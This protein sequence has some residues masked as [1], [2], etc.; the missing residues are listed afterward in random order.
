MGGAH[1]ESAQE[2]RAIRFRAVNR[3]GL[4]GHDPGLQRHHLLPLQ[5]RGARCLGRFIDG[6]GSHRIGFDDFRRNGMLLPT[7]ESTAIRTALPLHRGPHRLYSDLV[8]DRAG[9]IER[10]WSVTRL[11]NSEE[12]A[13]TAMM[14]L[15][16]L[17]RALRRRLLD[18]ARPLRLNWRTPLGSE[19]DFT[20]LDRMIDQLWEA[21]Q[22]SVTA[23]SAA[24]AA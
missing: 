6:I 20:E 4:P 15:G 3:R 8:M 21:S 18:P 12:A 11:R 9:Q 22:L 7:T 13:R 14:R 10:D 23:E 16:L 19:S 17:Q 2:L 5:L 24:F 1:R